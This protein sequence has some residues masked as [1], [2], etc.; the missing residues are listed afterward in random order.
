[1]RSRRFESPV[2]GG[3]ELSDANC[4]EPQ[5]K[6]RRATVPKNFI[7]AAGKDG[8]DL[9]GT[10]GFDLWTLRLNDPRLSSLWLHDKALGDLLGASRASSSYCP[11]KQERSYLLE[12]ATGAAQL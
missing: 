6:P 9:H 4:V 11:L 5:P 12:I 7:G 1:M 8:L 2:E 10:V 3:V